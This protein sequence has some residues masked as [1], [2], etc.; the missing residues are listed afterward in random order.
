MKI[1]D[2]E[3]AVLESKE[4]A[5]SQVK[6]QAVGQ[7][8]EAVTQGLVEISHENLNESHDVANVRPGMVEVS[9]GS[10]NKTRS[11]GLDAQSSLEPGHNVPMVT[12]W[13]EMDGCLKSVEEDCG[14]RHAYYALESQEPWP[15]LL[16]PNVEDLEAVGDVLKSYGPF[17][18]RGTG[19]C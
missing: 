2:D 1:I 17:M 3:E 16:D 10:F 12:D 15:E 4:N 19:G 6:N 9:C 5:P 13:P 14:R 8:L 7:F 11:V 18:D